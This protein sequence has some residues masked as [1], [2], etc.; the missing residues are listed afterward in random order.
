VF[1]GIKYGFV[2]MLIT[3]PYIAF[4]ILFSSAY[5]FWCGEKNKLWVCV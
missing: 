2:A 3:T 5:I 1:Y 4:S